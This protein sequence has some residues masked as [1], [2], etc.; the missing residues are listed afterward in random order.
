MGELRVY[1]Y[2]IIH[3]CITEEKKM[4]KIIA[5]L[6]A[7]ALSLSLFTACGTK[8]ADT[9][10]AADAGNNNA[11][12]TP[13]PTPAPAPTPS[14][15]A[16]RLEEILAAGKLVVGTSPDF[17]PMEFLD[18]NKSGQ[19]QYVG[20]DMEFARYIAQELGVELEIRAMDFGALLTAVG[21]GAIDMA[22]SGFAWREERA[23]SNELSD[24][25][26][27]QSDPRG[28]GL[29][30]MKEDADKYKT[31]AD[32]AG[33]LVAVQEA[34]LQKALLEEQIP[35]A[36]PKLVAKT[37]DGVMMLI[38][39]KVDAV[40]VSGSNGDSFCANYPEIQL[41]DF[42]YDYTSEGNVAGMM[43]GEVELA[44]RVNEI[45]KK[46]AAAG[47]F[48]KWY[49]EAQDLANDVGWQNE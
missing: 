35:D 21:A 14:A 7:I 15:P 45:I 34:S 22:L 13:T 16:N 24:F 23:E 9:P 8:P 25:Y 37:T 42:F 27:V 4:K 20:L 30:I 18:I 26:N 29:L 28:Q 39:G 49:S 11:T 43:K 48:E 36:E 47:L 10:P 3:F 33:K 32:F 1:Y 46:A 19:D 12:P 40:G 17:A 31:A 6:L 5:L 38:T 2:T 44:A 41:S